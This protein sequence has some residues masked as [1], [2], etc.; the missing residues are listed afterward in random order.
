MISHKHRGFTIIEL[1][2][3]VAL[4]AVLA[5]LIVGMTSAARSSAASAR[6]LSNLRQ[7]GVGMERYTEEN[8]GWYPPH[9][10]P[11]TG[12]SWYGAIAPYI[13]QEDTSPTASMSKIFHCPANPRPYN[14]AHNYLSDVSNNDQSYGYNQDRLSSNPIWQSSVRKLAITNRVNLVIVADIPT[15]GDDNDIVRF[16]ASVAATLILYP[17]QTADGQSSISGISR[18]HSGGANFLFIDGHVEHRNSKEVAETN[19][20]IGQWVPASL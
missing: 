12:L 10:S 3:V 19:F 18:R 17:A 5:S 15:F 7:I 20:D 2:L 6:C 8:Q 11:T 16:P 9:W 14:P 1:L 4:I 13:T